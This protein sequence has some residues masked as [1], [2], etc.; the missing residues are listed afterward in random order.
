MVM[1]HAANVSHFHLFIGD[2]ALSSA[3]FILLSSDLRA[4]ITLRDLSKRVINRIKFNF[5]SR[6]IQVTLAND[7]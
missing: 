1:N 6:K 4:L 3:S 7:V 5:V 2:I